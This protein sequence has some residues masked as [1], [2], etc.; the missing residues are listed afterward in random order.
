MGGRRR[1]A[2]TPTVA[3][4]ACGSAAAKKSCLYEVYGIGSDVIDR[5][6][7]LELPQRLREEKAFAQG[8]GLSIDRQRR[9]GHTR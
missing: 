8:G 6:L 2:E 1:R 3:G 5:G 9:P 4:C 7:V